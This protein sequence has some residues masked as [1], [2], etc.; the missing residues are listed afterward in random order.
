[1]GRNLINCISKM[2]EIEGRRFGSWLS[3]C[4]ISSCICRWGHKI[5]ANDQTSDVQCL[6]IAL[7]WHKRAIKVEVPSGGCCRGSAVNVVEG[8]HLEAR[9]HC[10]FYQ[11]SVATV[12]VSYAPTSHLEASDYHNPGGLKLQQ[13][14]AQVKVGQSI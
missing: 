1:M 3:I 2:L 4:E 6:G 13:A 11:G 12:Q 5:A 7:G 9:G 8:R 14:A 10:K